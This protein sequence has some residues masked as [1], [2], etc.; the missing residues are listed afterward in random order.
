MSIADEVTAARCAHLSDGERALLRRCGVRLE[1]VEGPP[2]GVLVAP[3]PSMPTFGEEDRPLYPWPVAGLGHHLMRLS[4]LSPG[5]YLGRLRREWL[6]PRAGAADE[7]RARLLALGNLRVVVVGSDAGRDL[8]LRG[9]F[10]RVEEWHAPT[11]DGVGFTQEWVAIPHPQVSAD[12]YEQ[13]RVVDAVRVAIGW[14]AS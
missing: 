7:L 10:Q 13:P 6:M 3:F 5:A 4:G 8:G 1:D 11:G 14:A 12:L 2:N 9:Y